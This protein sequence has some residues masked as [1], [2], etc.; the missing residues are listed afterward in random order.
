MGGFF[1]VVSRED[2]VADLFYGTDYHS[3]LG[4]ARGG[5]VVR[6][7][8]GFRRNI[9]DIS[10]SPFR[11]KFE[12]DLVKY[13]GNMGL[14]VISDTED[15]PLLIASR[16]GSYAI[17]TV[18]RVENADALARQTLGNGGGAHYSELKG[19]TFNAT[20]V[21]ASLINGQDT[22]LS[23]LQHVQERIKGSCSILLLADG[24]LY[25][26]RD[27][28][29]RTAVTLG[30]KDGARAVT[31]ETCAL[32]NL[33]YEVERHLGPGEIL[34]VTPD[35]CET[36]APAGD[37]MQI[38]AFLWIYYGYP[39]SNY[40]G[41]NTE[42]ARNRCGAA[43]ARA[44]STTPDLVAGI[45]DSG[46]GHAIGYA[47]EAGVPYR[48][49]FVKYTPTWPRSFMP[50]E[51]RV[52]DLVARM[53]LIP[54]RELIDGSRLLFCEDSIVRGTQLKDLICRIFDAG[55]R[56]VHMRPACPPL[57][58]GCRF[59][60]FSQSKSELDLAARRAVKALEG[61]ANA[62]LDDYADPSTD[63]YHA[64][65]DWIRGNLGLTTLQYQTLEDMVAAI[66]LPREQLCTY[67]WT[68]ESA[69]CE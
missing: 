10:N 28:L 61:D 17:V 58:H 21:V 27:R 26:A 24:G 35:G 63:R 9:H 56:E 62:R 51:Q 68:G 47:A 6:N 8:H 49:P 66:G 32:P 23:G 60:N 48:R 13:G 38:C 34:R 42:I 29:G 2:C 65:V 7:G 43:L 31:M 44:D 39:A 52:R 36:L 54:V 11:T 14:G 22:L 67:C 55:A 12:D 15:Q 19:N 5:M 53:K 57:V 37:R 69:G 41:V 16:H 45:P 1:G 3:H 25:A 50:Q 46:I 18:G 64:M 30:R 40:E 4:T 59:L 33:G 20:E